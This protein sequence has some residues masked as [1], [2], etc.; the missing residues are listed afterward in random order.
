MSHLTNENIIVYKGVRMISFHESKVKTDRAFVITPEMETIFD[1]YNGGFPTPKVSGNYILT[2]IKEMTGNDRIVIHTAR[3]NYCTNA[4]LDGV[5]VS[6]IMFQSGHVKNSTLY[7]Y[8]KATGR[9]VIAEI[10]KRR[11]K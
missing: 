1:K 2:S 11:T 4:F 7:T 5:P 3:R 10:T 9:E 6:E 8:I